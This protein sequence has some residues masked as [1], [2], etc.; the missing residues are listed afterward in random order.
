MTFLYRIRALVRW[1]FRRDELERALDTDLADYIARSAAEKMRAGMTEAQARRAARIELGGVEQTKDRVRATLALGPVETLIADAG[2]AFRTL[3]RQPTFTVVAVLTLALGIGV[4]VALF[5]LFQQLLQRPLPVADPDRLVNLNDPGPKIVGRSQASTASSVSGGADTVF[6]Y[7]TFRDL[8]RAQETLVELAAHRFFE[9]SLSTGERARLATGVFV[10]GS[11]FSVLGLQPVLGRLLGPEDDRVD[12]LAESVVLAHAYWQSELGGDPAVLGRALIVNGKP[13]TI[14]GVAPPGFDGT[15]VA[16]HASVFVPITSD[17]G[18]LIPNH[19]N[20][21]LYWVHLFARLEPG[22]SREEAAAAINPLYRAIVDEVEAP[23]L[24]NVDEHDLE[25]FRTRALVLE[26]GA[27]GQTHSRTLV[28]ARNSLEMLLAVC[29]A[30][31]LLCCTNVAG[32]MMVRGAAR[33]GE[34]AVRA[35]MGATRHRIA[36]LLLAESLALALPAAL[37]SLPVALLTLRGI[38]SGVP[39]IPTTGFDVELGVAAML[40]AVGAAVVSALAFGLFPLRDLIRTEPGKALQAYGARQT[41]SHGVMRF[42]MTLATVQIALSMALLAMTGVFA[43][44]LANIADIDLGLDVD[45]VVMFSISPLATTGYSPEASARVFDRLDEELRAIPGVSSVASSTVPVLSVGGWEGRVAVE[46]LETEPLDI[47][48]DFVSSDFFEMFGIGLLA[49]RGFS[50]ADTSQQVAIVNQRFAERLGL[51][52]S[53]I[54]RRIGDINAEIVGMVADA[55]FG[56]VTGDI[57]PRV[58]RPISHG[59]TFYVRSARPPADLMKAVREAVVRVDPNLAIT[60]LA[61]M[62]QQFLENIGTERFVARMSSAFAVLATVLAALGIYG[63][64]AFAVAQRSREI[65]L[66]FALG[67]PASRIRGMVVRQ[68]A[69]MAVTG[70]ALGVVAVVLLGRAAQGLLFGVGTADPAALAG[71]AIVLT[72]VMLGAAYIPARRASRVDPMTVLR[73]E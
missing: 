52:R 69:T 55:Q 53:V 44:T 71:A 28:P 27:R 35:S 12:G 30:V 64:L 48:T 72:A 18:A 49:G 40:V 38:A 13:L 36:S 3:R 62:E 34:M 22:V 23:L 20:R 14:V 2:Y 10:S 25:S 32:L 42:R 66:R 57:G 33:S 67:A 21:L 6:S 11:Y 70:L 16:S 8:E 45:S 31:L 24:T 15:T 47:S 41:S 60:R 4:N 26:P 29:G 5:S 59:L 63:V 54:G 43:R 73:Y 58:F 39:G 46:G 51:G 68:V 65:G 61:T 7:P 1:L 37:L 17:A 9:A 50:A 56:K 19:D